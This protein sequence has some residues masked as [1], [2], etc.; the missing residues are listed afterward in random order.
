MLHTRTNFS[1]LDPMRGRHT[2][3][4]Y[5]CRLS[6][7]SAELPKLQD[8]ENQKVHYRLL[9]TGFNNTNYALLMGDPGGWG[10]HVTRLWDHVDLVRLTDWVFI[11][12]LG[13]IKLFYGIPPTS[14]GIRPCPMSAH[15]VEITT[16]RAIL[17]DYYSVTI[18][19]LTEYLAKLP[20][21]EYLLV[22]LHLNIRMRV[23]GKIYFSMD[24]C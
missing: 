6:I 19:L 16:K 23:T 7:E 18:G 3:L 8:G 17:L 5:V 9:Y 1:F 20:G 24:A 22:G 21:F 10:A 13:T 11:C 12:A 4:L 15:D 14:S 2:C